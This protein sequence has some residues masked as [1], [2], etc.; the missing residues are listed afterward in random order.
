[1]VLYAIPQAGVLGAIAIGLGQKSATGSYETY[2]TDDAG[3]EL[4]DKFHDRTDSAIAYVLGDPDGNYICFDM[5]KIS[6][7]AMAAPFLG[8]GQPSPVRAE[9]TA[10]PGVEAS[11]TSLFK[12]ALYTA[13]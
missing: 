5:A 8:N 11:V 10:K 2:V 6:Y 7:T 13:P 12:F 4:M 1:M 9:W 3:L